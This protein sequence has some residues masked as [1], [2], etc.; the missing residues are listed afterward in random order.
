MGFFYSFTETLLHSLWQSGLLL[1]LWFAVTAGI[2]HV[3]P[4]QK[5][6][7]LYALLAAQVLVS[8]FTFIACFSGNSVSRTFSITQQFLSTNNF[9]SLQQYSSVIFFVYAAA[10]LFRS[11]NLVWQWTNFKTEYKKELIRPD[12]DLKLFTELKAFHIGIKRTVTLW[13]ST[14]I[15]APLTFG[16]FKPVIL[17]PFNLVNTISMAEAEAIILHELAHIKSK[18]Y[19]LNWLLVATETLYF[20]N[21]FIRIMA[22]KIRLEREK[23]CDV[24]V[25][26]FNYPGLLYAQTLL[27]I[28]KSRNHIRPF[29]LG[30]VKRTAHLLN[31]VQFFSKEDNLIFKK[32]NSALVPAAIL[33]LFMAAA[34]FFLPAIK[35]KPVSQ[36]IVSTAPFAPT[37]TPVPFHPAEIISEEKSRVNSAAVSEDAASVENNVYPIAKEEV[38]SNEGNGSFAVPAGFN[39]TPDSIKEFIYN[40]ETPQGKM[41]QSFKLRLINGQ[42]IMQPQWMV[43]Q[44]RP[45]SLRLSIDSIVPALVV[46]SIQ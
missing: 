17:L 11:G 6:N 7:F 37:E 33:P 1:L 41:T 42:W 39:E 46:D 36:T 31:R 26:N 19:L 20:F 4:L 34:V 40:I 12:V 44:T 24:Q 3:H 21:P 15:Q 2:T 18:D 45:D 8:I 32:R 23:N 14:A 25:I 28:A 13:Y 9:N 29:Q 5:R 10:V 38:Y 22:G 30:A 35:E 43:M 27:K 16:F